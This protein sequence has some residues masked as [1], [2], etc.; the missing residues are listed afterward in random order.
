MF[1]MGWFNHQLDPKFHE[2]PISYI[3][4]TSVSVSIVELG[5]VLVASALIPWHWISWPIGGM[6]VF[7]LNLMCNLRVAVI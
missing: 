5:K 4:V 7:L 6:V 3:P 2:I 1:E